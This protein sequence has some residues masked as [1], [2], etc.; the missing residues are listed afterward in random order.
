MR[1][2][3]SRSISRVVVAAPLADKARVGGHT[4]M[5]LQYL[6]GLQRRGFDVCLVDRLQSLV[7]PRRHLEAIASA[8]R[9]LGFMG[10]YVPLDVIGAC[11]DCR[12]AVRDYLSGC[13]LLMNINGYLQ[14]GDLLEAAP[15]KVFLDIDP[16]WPQMW[17]DLGLADMLA[18]HDAY[19]TVGGN[20]GKP[21]CVIPTCGVE[22]I[23]T[24][25]PVVLGEWPVAS[26]SNGKFTSVGSWRGAFGPIDYKGHTY[27]LRAHEFRKF[28]E[29]PRRTRAPFELALDIHPDEGPDLARLDDNGW[30][31]VDPREVARD[32]WRYREYVQHSA[33]EFMIA[34]NL[35]VDTRSGWFSDRSVCYLASGK[36]VLAQ[37]T[38]IRDLYP[39]GEGL[40][41]FSTV[42]EA[43]AGVEEI[44][45]HYA[46]HSKAARSIAAEY[47]DADKVLGDLF[48]A[49]GIA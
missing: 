37:D 29:L 12:T 45:G 38:G 44:R 8:L 22:W 11:A 40:L 5:V 15:L 16:G 20:L 33:A 4:W 23:H 43:A 28:M 32:P 48:T 7:A 3:S 41:V 49:L 36:P 2:A 17:R 21:G 6:L 18:G 47:F 9:S 10:R 13:H 25:P 1:R 14:D 27:G 46:R 39:S 31:L 34:K 30:Q 35:Y 26:R 24:R 42:D 19:V